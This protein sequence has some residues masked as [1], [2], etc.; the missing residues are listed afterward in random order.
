MKKSFSREFSDFIGNSKK[1]FIYSFIF[2]A[3]MNVLYL[4]SPVYMTIIYDRVMTSKSV[5]TLLFVTIALFLAYATYAVLEAVRGR[6]VAHLSDAMEKSLADAIIG[7]VLSRNTA[8]TAPRSGSQATRDL[9]V[10]RQFTAGPGTIA[11]LDLP[12]APFYVVVLFT[13]HPYLGAFALFACVTQF[14]LAVLIEKAG[15]QRV[16]EAAKSA[17]RSYQVGEAISRQ[18][19]TVRTMGLASGLSAKWSAARS[20]MIEEQLKGSRP[21]IVLSAMSKFSSLFFAS[22]A[23]GVGAL[24]AIDNLVSPGAVFAASLLLGRA[25][26][27]L[28]QAMAS[29]KGFLTARES[30]ANLN[31]LLLSADVGTRDKMTLPQPK[32]LLTVEGVSWRPPGETKAVLSNVNLALPAGSMTCIVGP[33]GGGKS[34]LARLCAGAMSPT[35]GIVRLDGADLVHWGDQQLG[36]AIGYL[37]Q[38]VALFPGSVKENLCRFS[39]MPDED[40]LKASSLSGADE[41]INQLPEGYQTILSDDARNI[42]GGQRQRIG[43]ARAVIGAPCVVILDEPNANLDT[44]G[45]AALARCLAQ[46]KGRGTTTI[47]V[48]HKMNLVQ[49]SDYVVVVSGGMASAPTPAKTF[50]EQ[51]MAAVRAAGSPGAQVA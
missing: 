29:W 44:V 6:L 17:A 9:D 50:I 1:I 30:L 25:M 22:A 5:E 39:D 10:I 23:L 31:Q 41:V 24:L 3:F 35:V 11:A 15:R 4:A 33:S 38:E 27:P 8:G 16:A 19:D 28:Q 37:P 20:D 14:A 46:L 7:A 26:Q 40:V 36:K 13:I 34:T 43:L 18:A 51:Q 49:A 21:V 32:G 42:S 47:I 45:E 48:S 2:S 12:W